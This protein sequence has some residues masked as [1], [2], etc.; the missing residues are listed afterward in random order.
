MRERERSKQN[1]A[2]FERMH[3][4]G[5]LKPVFMLLNMFRGQIEQAPLPVVILY[6]FTPH[7]SQPSSN[8]VAP[9]V[10]PG[11]HTHRPVSSGSVLS[12]S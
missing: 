7:S 3:W 10:N 6:V 1:E 5:W 4:L 2:I 8:A 12:L 9:P 11:E